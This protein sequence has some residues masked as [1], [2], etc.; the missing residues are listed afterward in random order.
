MIDENQLVINSFRYLHIHTTQLHKCWY[1]NDNSL[2]ILTILRILCPN[3]FIKQIMFK[4]V[5]RAVDYLDRLF[6]LSILGDAGHVADC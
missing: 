3:M 1:T 4:R 2:L 6:R 5:S